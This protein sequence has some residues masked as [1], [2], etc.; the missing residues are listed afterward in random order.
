MI[1]YVIEFGKNSFI[2]EPLNDID[3]VVLSQLAYMDFA[4][5]QTEKIT[6]IAQMNERQIQTVIENTW[7]ANQNAELLRVMQR[8]V[9]Y[10]F[11]K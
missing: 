8:R 7:R 1:D 4:Y 10:S 6:S 5:L 9:L 11:I 2:D 3:A